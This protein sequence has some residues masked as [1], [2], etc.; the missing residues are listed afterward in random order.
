MNKLEQV[1]EAGGR[2]ES[3]KVVREEEKDQGNAEEKERAKE[4]EEEWNRNQHE[5]RKE[6]RKV[7][8]TEEQ[9]A[10]LE[11]ET[12]EGDKTYAIH[13]EKVKELNKQMVEKEKDLKEILGTCEMT[14][15]KMELR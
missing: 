3:E 6:E 10:V 1:K 9:Q 7:S 5:D 11:K 2:E 14:L 4:E 15:N 8:Q 13:K 12:L